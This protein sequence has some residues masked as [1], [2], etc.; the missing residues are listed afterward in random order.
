MRRFQFRLVADGTPRMTLNAAIT[1][2]KFFFQVTLDRGELFRL[3]VQ[4]ILYDLFW[5]CLHEVGILSHT[6]A[7]LKSFIPVFFV[8]G[9]VISKALPGS[10][11]RV[12]YA[13][14]TS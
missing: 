14:A 13:F 11:A 4:C 6:D 12:V 1:G 5:C 9:R 7:A 2:L 8:T 3:T 10:A